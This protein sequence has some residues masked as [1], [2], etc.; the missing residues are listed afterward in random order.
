MTDDV[1][2]SPL[3]LGVLISGSGR[4]LVNFAE[5]IASG[6]LDAEIAC[7]ISDRDGVAGIERARELDLP[8]LVEADADRTFA[9]LRRCRVELVCLAGYLRLLRIPDDFAGRVINIHP[10]LLPEFGGKGFW[11]HHVHEAVLATGRRESGCT[12]HL[13]DDRY[14]TGPILLQRRVPVLPGDTPDA[15]AARVFAAECDAYPEAIELWRT[16]HRAGE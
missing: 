8:C 16:R 9:E 6:R 15:L 3:R 10:A 12:V 14:D 13:C 1:A 2:P 11:G 5:R 7:V 4:T